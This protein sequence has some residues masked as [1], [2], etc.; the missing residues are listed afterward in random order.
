MPLVLDVDCAIEVALDVDVGA[1]VFE[2]VFVSG[3]EEEAAVCALGEFV[4]VEGDDFGEGAVEGGGEFVGDDPVRFLGEGFG[5]AEAVALTIAEFVGCTK[6]ET[7]FAEAATA[8]EGES[9][10]D[11]EVEGVDEEAGAEVDVVDV[12][13]IR[14]LLRGSVEEA[15]FAGAGG[16]GEGD[17]V[18]GLDVECQV[19][20]DG[21]LAD[22]E[23]DAEVIHD[24]RG[25]AGGLLGEEV[26]GDG[27]VHGG[28][29]R[30]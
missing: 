4:Q 13:D 30:V 19:F 6:E 9:F 29:S 24:Q 25:V 10:G 17:D 26:V 12:E 5:E 7:G 1:Q 14:K 23:V 21:V 20:G 18:S 11:G 8:E 22:V 3:G 28:W 2:D 15:G 27:E 16:A